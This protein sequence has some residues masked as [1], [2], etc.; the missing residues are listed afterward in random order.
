MYSNH[1]FITAGFACGGIVVAYVVATAGITDIRSRHRS[2]FSLKAL[3]GI[4]CGHGDGY[5]T[6]G[7][8]KKPR[9]RCCSTPTP[10]NCS[11][12]PALLRRRKASGCSAARSHYQEVRCLFSLKCGV[13]QRGRSAARVNQLRL[14]LRS[15]HEINARSQHPLAAVTNS[16]QQVF[17]QPALTDLV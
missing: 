6:F 16:G 7:D 17:V 3:G 4:P 12:S 2:R 9:L 11:Q 8:G 13:F 5:G 14:P 1:V 10:A 15:Q